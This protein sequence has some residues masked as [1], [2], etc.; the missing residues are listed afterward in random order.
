MNET[1]GSTTRAPERVRQ[2]KLARR[3]M[4]TL[5]ETREDPREAEIT[6]TEAAMV[7]AVHARATDIH[8]DPHGGRY[9]LRFRIDGVMVDV[10]DLE[11]ADGLQLVNQFR[12]LARLD[13]V[14]AMIPDAGH[15]SYLLDE[16]A[17]DLRVTVAPCIGGDKLAI[18]ILAPA[19]VLQNVRDLGLS[20][21]QV[22]LLDHW[23]DTVGGML[24]ISGPTGS[25]KTTTLYSLLH[26]LKMTDRHIVT[27]EDPVEYEIPG[28]N[29]MRVDV[30][31][32]LGF[33]AGARAMLRLDP[34]YQV[35]G[36][37]I[38]AN[39]ARAAMN[40]ASGGKATLS[41]LHSRDAADVISVL[42]N[43]G[44]DDF[45]LAANLQLVVAQRLVRRL[46]VHCR[47]QDAPG[48]ADVRW[49]KSLDLPVPD[50]AWTAAGC[51]R[52]N[53]LG[54]YGR[55]GIFEVWR[56]DDEDYAKILDH[57]SAH[58]IRAG[59][60]ERGHRFLLEDGLAKAEEGLVSYSELH[61]LGAL[62]RGTA[63][64]HATLVAK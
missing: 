26:Q 63:R 64:T 52:C 9:R 44:L 49:L 40:A 20:G 13:P 51:E 6:L 37:L 35:I 30:E 47:R 57:R 28:I 22:E 19:R 1:T 16:A 39:S 34:D 27:L 8:L 55:I 41:T 60:A 11:H 4:Q 45:E 23:L 32:G 14:T 36:E 54:Y 12:V 61:S 50:A 59:L 46:C 48:K 25:G 33:A 2:D 10:A 62:G 42:R 17:L 31:R 3:L 24:L 5:Q 7:D 56:P 29:Q 58:E 18:R 43:Y 38:E 53:D 15:F 21:Q